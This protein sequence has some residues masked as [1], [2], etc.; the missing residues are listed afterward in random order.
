MQVLSSHD[1][2]FIQSSL[3]QS[4]ST[5]HD[6]RNH[7]QSAIRYDLGRLLKKKQFDLNYTLWQIRVLLTNTKQIYRHAMYRKQTK[8]QY[9]RDDPSFLAF[10]CASVF[11]C[12]ALY[13]VKYDKRGFWKACWT[14]LCAVTFDYVGCG[15]IVATFYWFLANKYMRASRSSF[16]ANGSWNR[17][18][19]AERERVGATASSN[20]K[21]LRVE[22]LFAFDVHCNSFVPLFVSLYVGQLVLSPILAQTGFI[23]AFLSNLLFAISLSY[24]HYCQFVGFNSLPFLEKTEFM[25]YPVLVLIAS[26]VPLSIFQFN[27]TRY[28]L[29]W[30]FGSSA[31]Q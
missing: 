1:N 8:G 31:I 11:V 20:D 13:C 6:H 12:A 17:A 21:L 24:Y 26:I 4:S 10:S 7:L 23:A 2:R 29:F 3:A 9:A 16:E 18:S 19:V 25:L 27:P 30:Y 15:C 5:D 22:W 28:V 14:C